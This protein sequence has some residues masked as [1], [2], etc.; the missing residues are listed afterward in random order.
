MSSSSLGHEA[1]RERRFMARM[2]E[3]AGRHKDMVDIATEIVLSSEGEVPYSDRQL[4]AAAYRHLI[5]PRRASWRILASSSASTAKLNH[6]QKEYLAGVEHE[7]EELC[8]K[9]VDVINKIMP[10]QKSD[11]A[12]LFFYKMKGDYFRYLAEISMFRGYSSSTMPD[13]VQAARRAYEA[14]YSLAQQYWGPTDPNYLG[15][16]LNFAVFEKEILGHHDYACRMVEEAF[17]AAVQ[18]LEKPGSHRH[19]DVTPVLQLLRENLI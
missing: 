12:K 13:T 4:F 8:W 14:A 19:T 9:V 5:V 16:V 11:K 15:L 6:I 2:A 17:S 7:L 1:L 3:Q 18:A 10:L